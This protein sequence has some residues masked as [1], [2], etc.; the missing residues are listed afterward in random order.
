VADAAIDPGEVDAINGH[1]TA[2]G[3]D[4]RE[5]ASWAKALERTP[6]TFPVIT[7]TKSMIG[8]GLGAA[9]GLEA[10]ACILMLEGGFVHP[11]I[12]C[13]DVHPEIEAYAASIP[14]EV[15][16]VPELN[17]IIKAGFGFGDVNSCAIFR[18][19]VD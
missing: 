18:R 6:E 13:E 16:E 9:G 3:A 5:V 1:L 17:T 19:S 15:R 8:H 2:T 7:S 4:P 14:H 12:N 11:S 10:V